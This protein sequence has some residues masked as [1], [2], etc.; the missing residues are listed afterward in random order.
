MDFG[1]EGA[2]LVQLVASVFHVVLYVGTKSDSKTSFMNT[3]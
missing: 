3:A 2:Y 1:G